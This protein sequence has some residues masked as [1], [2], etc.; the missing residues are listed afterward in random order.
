MSD[1]ILVAYATRYGST[2]QVAEEIAATLRERGLEVVLQPVREMQDLNG[3]RAIVLGAPLYFG[4][5][6]K[7]ARWF[8]TQHQ[9][10]LGA[11]PLAF[12]ALGPTT[13][14]RREE[15]WQGARAQLDQELAKF[16][17]LAPV[18]VEL[19][20]GKYDPARLRLADRLIASLPASP[21]HGVPASDSRDWTVVRA[22]ADNLAATL[23][24]GSPCQGGV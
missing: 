10:S 3:C 5:L 18:A 22:W 2:R 17:W 9:E 24:S 15:E 21:L 16:P 12:F 1:S 14:P 8:L 6:H 4:A 13:H 11:R 23:Q 19:F 7:D 20:G